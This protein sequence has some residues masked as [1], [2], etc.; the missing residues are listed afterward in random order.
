MEVLD[1]LSTPL[2][3][4]EGEKWKQEPRE[5]PEEYLGWEDAQ[6]FSQQAGRNIDTFKDLLIPLSRTKDKA[7]LDTVWKYINLVSLLHTVQ[8]HGCSPAVKNYQGASGKM[9]DELWNLDDRKDR[10]A[11]WHA[12]YTPKADKD[13][14]TAKDAD[15]PPALVPLAAH[16]KQGGKS[17]TKK[18]LAITSGYA[19]DG[20]M[21]SLQTV[22][23]SSDEDIDFDSDEEDSDEE[24]ETDEGSDYDEELEEELRER[25]REAMD[26]AQADP[27]FH[28]PRVQAKDFEE[29]AS[30]KQDNPFVKLL[31]SLRGKTQRVRGAPSLLLTSTQVVCSRVAPP[32]RPRT[33]LSPVRPTLDPSRRHLRTGQCLPQKSRRRRL[34][35]PLL[36]VSRVWHSQ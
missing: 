33:V 18:P 5:K 22:S 12:F 28:N 27:D 2:L 15:A 29:M 25:L 13:S 14:G 8:V 6:I 23:D 17:G 19:S 34:R 7:V 3:G 9:I 24:Y 35:S 4:E 16:G 31:G 36:Q 10:F 1:L 21:P 11:T 30:Y 26:M 32:L 20:S